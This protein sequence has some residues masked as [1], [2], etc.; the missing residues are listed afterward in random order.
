MGH[1][2]LNMPDQLNLVQALAGLKPLLEDPSLVKIG[3]NLKLN[4]GIL[5]RYNIELVGIIF[6]TMIE[7]YVLDSVSGDHDN[8]CSHAVLQIVTCTI[9]LL[10]R[11]LLV[12]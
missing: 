2:Y 8:I 11:H 5:K 1:H 12:R 4:Y 9:Q 6:D 7:S 3:Q 10:I